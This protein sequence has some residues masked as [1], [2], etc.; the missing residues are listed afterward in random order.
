M[1]KKAISFVEIIISISIIVLLASIWLSYKASY[2]DNKFNTKVESDLASLNNSFL[3]YKQENSTLP[4]P[5]W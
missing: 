5:G 3:S 4:N 1:N 2:D